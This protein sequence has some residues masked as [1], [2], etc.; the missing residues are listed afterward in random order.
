MSRG[1]CS[2][3]GGDNAR[4][5]KARCAANGLEC[6]TVSVRTITHHI[7][8]PW[9][10]VPSA[11]KYYFCDDPDCAVAYF[12]D[13]DSIV[14]KSQLRTR[15]GATERSEHALLCYCFGISR[16]DFVRDPATREYVI[17]QTRTGA[18]SCETSNPA[19]R[20]CLKDFPKS[21]MP[22]DSS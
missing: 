19:G 8:Q 6:S 2:S 21:A 7:T 1:C 3:S 13:D 9:A 4:S 12:G 20:C 10:W 17:A 18:C 14:L 16:A 22:R 5:N 15:L 11:R